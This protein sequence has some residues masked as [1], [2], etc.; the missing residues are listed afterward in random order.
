[1]TTLIPSLAPIFQIPA[2]T[3]SQISALSIAVIALLFILL[4]EKEFF[5]AYGMET[6]RI[7]LDI[8]NTFSWSLLGVLT[9]LIAMRF[10]G[11]II[12]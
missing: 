1:M 9:Y 6:I 12:N 5:R 2:F 3:E 4:V 10:L 7:W 8:F 11:F